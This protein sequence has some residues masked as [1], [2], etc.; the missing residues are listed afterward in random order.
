MSKCLFCSK[1]NFILQNNNWGVD[2]NEKQHTL[3]SSIIFLKKHKTK[4]TELDEIELS[5]L[6]K[7]QL[8]YE[9]RLDKLFKPNLY[10]LLLLGNQVSH[11]HIHLIPR[12]KT[13]RYFHNQK[14]IDSN[15]GNLVKQ[16]RIKAK[17]STLKRL[18][19]KIL[20]D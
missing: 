11:L 7:I 8:D 1:N 14:F 17:N 15:Y 6:Q 12:Y 2:L 16:S 9:K 4:F 5:D 19:T 20:S 18:K 3:G 10:N 13:S